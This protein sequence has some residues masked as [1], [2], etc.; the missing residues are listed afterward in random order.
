MTALL[1]DASGTV[2][3]LE[4]LTQIDIQSMVFIGRSVLFNRGGANV[5]NVAGSLALAHSWA[6]P[7]PHGEAAANWGG[8]TRVKPPMFCQV[9]PF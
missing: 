1:S 9:L 4:S 3:G 8:Y 5:D 7:W 6:K 2:A